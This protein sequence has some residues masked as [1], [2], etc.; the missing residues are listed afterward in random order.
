MTMPLMELELK[1]KDVALKFQNIQ[2]VSE[3][4]GITLSMVYTMARGLEMGSMQ[5]ARAASHNM[6]GGMP[7]MT[8]QG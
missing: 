8:A 3:S 6:R 5:L 1:Q 4:S 7:M 2:H